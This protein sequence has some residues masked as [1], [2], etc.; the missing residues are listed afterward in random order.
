MKKR[1]NDLSELGGKEVIFV[2][3]DASFSHK[4]DLAFTGVLMF[5]SQNDHALSKFESAILRTT[6]VAVKSNIRAELMGVLWALKLVIQKAPKIGKSDHKAGPEI[7]LYTDCKTVVNLP[8]RRLTLEARSFKSRRTGARLKNADLYRD[9]F[10]LIDRIPIQLFWVK[11][12]APKSGK[13]LYQRNFSYI[14]RHIRRE[15]RA[16][17]SSLQGMKKR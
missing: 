11:G 6:E 10:S 8:Q 15:L 3:S 2:Y 13:S 9:F 1:S 12:H 4:H 5:P 16:K 7:H 14:D 17:I